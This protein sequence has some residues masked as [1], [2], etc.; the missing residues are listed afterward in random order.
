LDNIIFA[1][2]WAKKDII[3]PQ[4]LNQQEIAI[5]LQQI[6]TN[7]LKYA[8]IENALNFANIK[9]ATSS[10]SLLYII[11]IPLVEQ[12]SYDVLK[13]RTNNIPGKSIKIPYEIVFSNKTKI[14]GLKNECQ[15]V[16]DS[17]IC[18]RNY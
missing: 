15:I 10:Q 18:S 1:I 14:Y 11:N 17:R 7:N 12:E 5:A 13:I 6:N 2:H 3:N 8:T 16:E 4:I 9:I